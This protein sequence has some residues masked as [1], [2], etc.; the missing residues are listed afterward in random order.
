MILFKR[1]VF[2]LLWIAVSASSMQANTSFKVEQRP[3]VAI[4]EEFGE[5]YQ[6]FFSYDVE[7]IR[8]VMVDFDFKINESAD[9]AIERLLSRT[10]L[11]YDTFGVKYFVIYEDTKKGDKQAKKLS[12][13]IEQIQRLENSGTISL[14]RNQKEPIRQFTAVVNTIASMK[15]TKIVR[16]TVTNT[17]GETLIGVNILVKG[18]SIGIATDVDGTYEL[19][20]PD[21]ATV[22]IFSYTGFVKQEVSIDGREVVNVEMK[23]DNLLIDEVVIIGYGTVRR[24]DA[25]GALQ[26][27]NS[28]SFNKGAITSPQEL[29]AGKVAGVQITPGAAPGDGAVIRIRGGSSL[30]ATNDPLIIIDGVPVSNDGISGSRN[31]LNIINPSDIE[32]FTVLKDASA[33]AIY[34]SRASNGVILITTK[35]GTFGSKL[36]L[37]YNGN[38]AFSNRLNEIDVLSADEYRELIN[39]RFPDGHPSRSLLGSANT[40]WQSEI[41]QTGVTHDHNVSLSGAAGLLPYRVSLGYTNRTGV[42]KNDQ[43]SRSTASIN[44][45]P[46]FLNNALQVNVSLKG[47][48]SGDNFADQGAIGAAVSFDP[49][50]SVFDDKSP[51]GGYFTWTQPNG[52]PITVAPTNPLALLNLR[53]SQ[54]D[55]QRYILNANAD[56]RFW[57][58]P[59]LRANLNLGYDYS[60]GEGTV[61]VP[62]NAAFTFSDGGRDEMYDQEQKNELLEFYLNY[63]KDLGSTRLDVL[64]GYSWQH[65]FVEDNF[66]A[67]N[68]D[69]TK[70]LTP[71]ASNPREYYLL[72]L[73]GRLNYSIQEKYIFTLTMRRDGTSRF[74]EDNRWGLFPAAAFAWKIVEKETAKG[75]SNLKLR[76][77]YGVT[78]QQ[79]IGGDFYPYLARYVSSF[80]NARYQLGNEFITTLRP[81]GY[82]A[83]IKW[84]ETTTYNAGFDYGFLENR[85]YGSIDVYYRKT[86]DLINFIPVPAGT[87]L[88]NFINTNVGDLE[89]RGVELSINAIPYRNEKT[90]WDVG[91]NVTM[92]RNEITR[93]TATEDPNYLGVFTGGI[94]GGVGNTI[95]IHSVGFPANSFFVYEQVYDEAGVPVEGLYVDRNK[96]GQIT[97]D[98]RYHLE[99]PAPDM[100]FGFNSTLN[101]GNWDFS[102]AGR[103]NLGNYVYNNVLSNQAFY[104]SLYNSNGN[105][106][107]VHAQ[108]ASI[109]FTIPQYFSD[110]FIEDASFLRIDHITVGHNFQN[111]FGPSRNLRVYGTVQNPILITNYEGLDPEVFSGID[112]NIYPR[113]RTFLIGVSANF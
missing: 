8:M 36:R 66:S 27:V 2:I 4:L 96:D 61:F 80:E 104:N 21:D 6:V 86:E 37:D 91:F 48:L 70:I 85:L 31:P 11:K 65:F 26:T 92:N 29:L 112:G 5:K 78:G 64:G 23:A 22:L 38:V 49:T 14:Q 98:D 46:K 47:M 110:Y 40:D 13:K 84:E 3:L 75:L 111:L 42:L 25:T 106:N 62:K 74:S 45:S 19:E 24:E 82:D 15:A 68:V 52:N 113:S 103:A 43:F 34:G 51:Y 33:T 30:S 71:A 94:A 17:Q 20:I 39:T 101:Y 53:E 67:T 69:G 58:L 95:Q 88:T 10:K 100:F 16:G 9:E 18:T 28:R 59:D 81:N 90:T 7:V 77:G 108:T 54:S 83:N 93:L 56:Y 79:G 1:F 76:L 63:G 44:L 89:N 102:F 35:K 97:P 57:F 41:F 60:K 73:F 107:N 105:L 50:Q 12:R 55:V 99:K 72:S 109:D 87:N 32:T